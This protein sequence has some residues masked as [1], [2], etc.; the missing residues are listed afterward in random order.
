MNTNIVGWEVDIAWVEYGKDTWFHFGIHK[1][2]LEGFSLC[3]GK[4]ILSIGKGY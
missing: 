1:Q 2:P 3:L 4:L